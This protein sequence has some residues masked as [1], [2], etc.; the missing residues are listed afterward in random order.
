MHAYYQASHAKI[1]EA[2]ELA[3]RVKLAQRVVD[4][5]CSLACNGSESRECSVCFTEQVST[6]A[7]PCRHS[8]LCDECMK[9]VRMCSGQCP[10]CR[11]KIEVVYRGDFRVEYVDFNPPPKTSWWTRFRQVNRKQKVMPGIQA[12]LFAWA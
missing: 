7:W 5:P 10:I 11:E 4:L 12:T 1:A 3:A 8:L 2:E 9:K 6:I